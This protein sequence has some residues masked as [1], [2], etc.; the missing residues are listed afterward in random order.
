[1]VAW[2]FFDLED[3]MNDISLKWACKLKRYPD[4][5]IKKF[6]SRLC[7]RGDM[8]LEGIDLFDTYAPFT[9]WSAILL[10]LILEIILQLKSKQGC[11]TAAFI[12]AKII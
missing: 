2:D 10:I 6:K 3:D 1:M 4:G 11:V 5:L 12:Y 9:Q 7:D 8:Q